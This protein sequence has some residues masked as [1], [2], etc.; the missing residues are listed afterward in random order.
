[1]RTLADLARPLNLR[2]RRRLQGGHPPA[3]VLMTDEARLP[4]PLPVAAKL[5]PGSLVIFRHYG[6]PERETIARALAKLCRVKRLRLLVA[7]DFTLAQSLGAGLHLP[8]HLLRQPLA[9]QRLRARAGFLLTTACHSR[10]ALKRAENLGADACL[11][12]PVFATA[13][14]PGVGGMGIWRFTAWVRSCRLT[15]YGLGGLNTATLPRLNHSQSAGAAAL[16][17]FL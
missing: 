12:S 13:S 5:P 17:G 3:L 10:S 1:M 14:H 4:D 9:R 15:V 2:C 7:K 11:L 6:H 16:S 8:E